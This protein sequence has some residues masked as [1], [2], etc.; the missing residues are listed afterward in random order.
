MLFRSICFVFPTYTKL[1]VL[2]PPMFFVVVNVIVVFK[3]NAKKFV[4]N[5]EPPFFKKMRLVTGILSILQYIF[6]F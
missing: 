1:V 6:V 4:R 2:I 3:K 5:P